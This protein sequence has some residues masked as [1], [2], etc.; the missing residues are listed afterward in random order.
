MILLISNWDYCAAGAESL[1]EQLQEEGWS[2]EAGLT[3][4][5]SR[6]LQPA[7]VRLMFFPFLTGHLYVLVTVGTAAFSSIAYSVKTKITLAFSASG[8]VSFLPTVC[9]SILGHRL[10]VLA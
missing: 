10:T 4:C 7:N 9:T 5:T 8:W 1:I 6:V 3:R 2:P